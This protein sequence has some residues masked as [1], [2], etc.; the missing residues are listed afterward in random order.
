[1]LLWVPLFS[2]LLF[3]KAGK[4]GRLSWAPRVGHI[5]GYWPNWADLFRCVLA[6]AMLVK[7][8]EAI[9]FESEES[10]VLAGATITSIPLV[11]FFLQ[12]MLVTSRR[13]IFVP[14]PI[15]LASVIFI[16]GWQLG[17]FVVFVAFALCTVLKKFELLF[18]ILIVLII[19]V[20]DLFETDFWDLA[21]AVLLVASPTMMA[22]VTRKHLAFPTKSL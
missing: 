20:G 3:R 11:G 2:T 9:R 22:F 13:A 21:S 1:M 18:V 4:V 6:L 5:L 14:L 7:W 19:I 10:S 8:G 15:I 17:L 16:P 12:T